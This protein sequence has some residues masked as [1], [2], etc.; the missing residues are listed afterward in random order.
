MAAPERFAERSDS[1]CTAGANGMDPALPAGSS[2]GR[3]L[4]RGRIIMQVVRIAWTWRS[5]CLRFMAST[6]M[7][8][9]S[10]AKPCAA[11]QYQRFLRICL[12]VWS[13]SRADGSWSRGAPDKPSVCG[14]VREIEQKRSERCR[15]YLRGSQ[16]TYDALCSAEVTRTAC[17]PSA[18]S[19]SPAPGAKPDEAREYVSSCDSCTRSSQLVAI[20]RGPYTSIH[21]PFV[22]SGRAS[23]EVSSICRMRVLHQ[24]I[25]PHIGACHAPGHHGYQRACDLINVQA[26]TGPSGPP[27]FAR[28][29]KTDPLSRLVLSQTSAG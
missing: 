23:Q 13:G 5:T 22:W 1:S 24:C 16:P 4:Q 21:G 7:A 2:V 15:S 10:Y 17:D 12:V 28:T 18:P 19:D 20:G 26:S 14:T 11:D 27:V 8:T 25:R 3:E 9:L 6:N 29:G